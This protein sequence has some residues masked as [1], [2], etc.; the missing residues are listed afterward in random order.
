MSH[1]IRHEL[2][3]LILVKV[4]VLGLIW[5]SFFRDVPAL[6]PTAHHVYAVD[7]SDTAHTEEDE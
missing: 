4:L 7:R 3:G 1:P 5:W 2:F 6:A